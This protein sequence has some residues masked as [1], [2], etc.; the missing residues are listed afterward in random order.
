MQKQERWRLYLVLVVI[1]VTLISVVPV[2]QGKMP[3]GLDLK[4]GVHI[5][6]QAKPTPGN[7]L[8]S[9]SVE[10]LIA[11]IRNRIDQYGIA[12]PVIQRQGNDKVIIDLPGVSDPEAALDLIG[13]TALLQ[14]RSV[15]ATS[16]EVPP[17]P[18]RKNYGSDAEY[19]RA[20]ERWKQAKRE[21]DTVA[22]QMALQAK[23]DPKVTIAKDTEGRVYLLGDTYLEG[24]DLVD[25]RTGFD[26]FNRPVVS[27]KFNKEGTRLFDQATAI[28]VGKQIAIVLDGVVI[29]APVVQERISGGQAQISGRF[30][31]D[32]AN[33]LAIML[34]AGA[35]P[36]GVEVVENRAIG[37]S[38]GADSV[39]AGIK[40]G[41]VGAILVITF[42]FLYY[43][44]LGI[45]ANIA[46]GVAILMILGT[47]MALKST[48][49]LPGIAG[50][51]L[52][53]GMA[54]DGN[55]IIYERMREERRLGKTMHA[56]LEAGFKKALGVILDS[57]IT[58][59]ISGIVLFYFGTGPI[60]GFAVTLS[61][62]IVATVFCNVVVTRSLLD[63]MISSGHKDFSI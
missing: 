49:T 32:E 27:L 7:P 21:V 37:P 26:N 9:D 19:N 20:L 58:T 60:R 13:K 50:I 8:T 35:L 12:E 43:R 14:F 38:L 63:L 42:M 61:I 29:S 62:G 16:P 55:I 23:G 54:V 28:N 56:A 45:A 39:H 40:A 6:L 25:A 51:V 41:I 17:G 59:L 44:S 15:L 46:M 48:M 57:N 36:V 30:T 10:R 24:K 18:E 31:L 3:L 2:F 5:V 4:G 47:M 52:T 53:M 22:A 1:A 11:V 33:R 34:R